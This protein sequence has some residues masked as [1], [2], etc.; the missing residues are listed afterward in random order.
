MDKE[1]LIVDR[2]KVAIK[3]LKIQTLNKTFYHEMLSQY[4][5][6]II[7]LAKIIPVDP[8]NENE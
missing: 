3:F 4:K 6:S 1:I 2:I 7:Q 5:V 8:P